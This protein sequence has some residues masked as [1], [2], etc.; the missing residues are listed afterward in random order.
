M[1]RPALIAFLLA[2]CVLAQACAAT[3][4]RAAGNRG[5]VATG[6]PE[7]TEAALRTMQRGG[8]AI[9]AA[10]A[11]ALMLGVVDGHNSGLGGGCFL[12]IRLSDGTLVAIDG[13]ETAPADATE[14]M[15]LRDGKAVPELSLTGPLAAGVPGSLAAYEYAARHYGR[16]PLREH[17]ETAARVADE[18]FVVN[19]GYAAVLKHNIETLARF[20]ATRAVLLR[21]DGSPWQ[22][23]DRLRQ[24]DLA[25]SYRA[26]ADA[27]S[28][29]F[30]RG[31][32]AQATAR[33]MHR[34]GG[35]LTERDFARYRIKLRHPIRTTYRDCVIVGFPPPSSGGV[36]VAQVLNMIEGFDLR[37]MKAGSADSVHLLAEA[38]KRAFADR[39]HWLGD[40]DFASVPLGLVSKDYARLLARDMKLDA[41]TPVVRHGEPQA[42]F[43]GAFGRHTTHFSTADAE[44]NWVACTATLNTSFGC[45]DMVPGTGIVLNNQM[46]DFSAQP[47]ATNYF[48][49]PGAAANA[50]AP[51]KRP[52]SSMSPTIVLR[53]G[54]PVLAVGASGGP[55]IISQTLLALVNAIDFE[56]DI[57]AALRQP[58][59]HHQWQPD[60]LRV[61]PGVPSEVRLELE[62][63][64]HAV[65][66]TPSLSATQ[67]VAA[68]PDGGLVA[69]SDPRSGGRAGAW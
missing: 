42:V 59:F 26:L 14:T 4:A 64:G 35:L 18:G 24:R 5:A 50:V 6:A 45:K 12:L 53:N 54:R 28:E 31:R 19:A 8:N 66:Q 49:L 15:Y 46:D 13:R 2:G 1:P 7:A 30:Y 41:A 17:F 51:G 55:T 61:E 38:L 36:H 40:P 47:G 21:P 39:A 22:P 9:D 33:W 69:V 67:A 63:R 11:A 44:G 3:L 32:F 43:P 34:E 56:M 60:V 57:E 23:G 48:G 52:L 37:S 16:R 65:V 27:G 25:R 20:P 10:I 62:R 29:W 58:R 68:E